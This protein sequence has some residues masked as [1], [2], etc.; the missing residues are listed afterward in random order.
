MKADDA[1]LKLRAEDKADLAVVSAVLQDALVPLGDVAYF[2]DEGS[3]VMAANRFRWE[4]SA[5]AEGGDGRHERVHVGLRFDGVESVQYRNIDLRDRGRFLSFLDVAYEEVADR[6]QGSGPQA[7]RAMVL[8][9][10]AGD[11]AIRL[12]VNGLNCALA[13]LGE[14]WPT[15]WKPEHDL[16]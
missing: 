1:P 11:A 13:D 15:A 9:R 10:F 4:R 14:P 6:D 5:G 12:T 3:F 7:A 8:M 16:D 2:A